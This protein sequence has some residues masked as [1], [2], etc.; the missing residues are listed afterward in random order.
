ARGAALA[1]DRGACHAAPPPFGAFDEGRQFIHPE[2]QNGP[3]NAV[4]VPPR[5]GKRQITAVAFALNKDPFGVKVG[6]S[7]DPIQQGAD[8]FHRVLAFHAV[9]EIEKRLAVTGGPAHIWIDSD[10]A[11]FV[12][13]EVIVITKDRA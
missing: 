8:V 1:A 7:L 4:A 12:G 13:E 11:Q 2:I 9:V 10:D 6:L 5:Y 3:S